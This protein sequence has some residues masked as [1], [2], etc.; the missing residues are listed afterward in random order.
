V[1]DLR[2]PI[3]RKSASSLARQIAAA[4]V[5]GSLAVGS[6]YA[7]G[8]GGGGGG[9]GGAKMQIATAHGINVIEHRD[10]GEA[11]M[12]GFVQA[13]LAG[14]HTTPSD[15]VVTLN[16]ARLV[17]VPGLAPAWF[18]VD[19]AGE[20]PVLGADGFLHI[21]ASSVSA[22]TT[23]TLNLPCPAHLPVTTTPVEDSSLSGAPAVTLAWAF[24]LVQNAAAVLTF[25]DP[26]SVTLASYDLVS[27]TVTGGISFVSLPQSAMDATV[28]VAPTNSSGYVV[29][30]NYPGQY[31]LDGNSGG[32][33]AVEERFLFS[34]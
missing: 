17:H 33:C 22:N 7:A 20:Q 32:V 16:G 6:A 5:I 3:R 25:F 4:F 11:S 21:T 26:P 27:G 23:R 14:D 34:R 1:N 24:P 18:E 12:T 10:V 9:G 31:V 29:K 30:F 15:T 28:A 2:I 19:P 8:G 13:A